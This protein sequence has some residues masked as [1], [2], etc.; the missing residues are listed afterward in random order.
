MSIELQG[1]GEKYDLK[2]KIGFPLSFKLNGNSWGLL[3]PVQVLG[4]LSSVNLAEIIQPYLNGWW[5]SKSGL[6]FIDFQPL[7]KPLKKMS[8]HQLVCQDSGRRY[9]QS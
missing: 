9:E 8:V 3:S 1:K 5:K 6:G 2:V 4:F 7:L